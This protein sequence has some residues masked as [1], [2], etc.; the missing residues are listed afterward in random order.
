MKRCKNTL[1]FLQSWG[2]QR[3]DKGRAVRWPEDRRLSIRLNRNPQADEPIAP[4]VNSVGIGIEEA[5]AVDRE[6]DLAVV[7]TDPTE[8]RTF[9]EILLAGHSKVRQLRHRESSRLDRK[10]DCDH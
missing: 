5:L 4:K 7:V 3:S 6:V 8:I 9:L 2:R 10:T 1:G